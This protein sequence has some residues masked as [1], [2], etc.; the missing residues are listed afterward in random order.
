MGVPPCLAVS[1]L[2]VDHFYCLPFVCEQVNLDGATGNIEFNEKGK[3]TG[4]ELD[5]LN[6]RNNS[7]VK[8]SPQP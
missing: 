2:A 5:I 8:V 4:V 3:R 1:F 7:F 6:L